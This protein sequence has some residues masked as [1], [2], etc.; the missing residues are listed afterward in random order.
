MLTQRTDQGQSPLYVKI[1]GRNK[2]PDG[3]KQAIT[4]AAELGADS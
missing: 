3:K 2:S 1:C 4:Q